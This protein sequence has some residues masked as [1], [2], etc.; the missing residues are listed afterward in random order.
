MSFSSVLRGAAGFLP[1]LIASAAF[2]HFGPLP[3]SLV[4]APVP[5]VPGLTDG[6]DPIVVDEAAA[7]ALGKALFWDVN[8][9]SDGMACASCHFHA[10]SDGRVVNQIAPQGKAPFVHD[11]VFSP[12]HGPNTRLDAAAFPLFQTDDPLNP[13]GA[14][15][16][17]SDDVVS[18]SGSFGGDFASVAP[19]GGPN[20]Q[21]ERAADSVFHVGA[22]GTRRVEPR[23]APTVIN[24]VFNFRN[25][26][27]G[28]ANNVF[29]GSSQWGDRDPEAG[30]WVATGPASVEKQRLHLENA[31]LASQALGPPLSDVEMSCAQRNFAEL[32]R[33]LACRRPL[34]DQEV[35]WE[36]GVLG[37]L[38]RSTPGQLERGL[39]TNYF[40]LVTEAFAAKYWSS[41]ARGDFGA[42][43]GGG[44]AYS[45][46]EANFAMFFG[47]AIQLYEA[48]LIS[49]DSPF[50]RSA[51]DAN[52]IPVELSV[53]EQNGFQQFR[54]A[55]CGLCH[56]GPAFT[57]E[58]DR[59]E[60]GD[61]GGGSAGV[62]LRD[63][64]DQHDA[65]RRDARLRYG[66][67][68]IL[69]T[70]FANNGVALEEWDRG[71]GGNDP[72][73]N[74]LSF[75]DQYLQM[76]AGNAPRSSI[77]ASTRCVPATS[78]FRSRST[79]RRSIRRSSARRRASSAVAE[80]PELLPRT[81]AFLPTPA[82]AAAELA[83]STNTRMRSAAAGSFKI[84]TLRNIELT[85]PYMHNGSMATLDEVLEFYTRGG[86][87]DPEAKHFG[88]VFPQV[89]LRF[90]AQARADI[91]AFLRTL[92][93]DRVRFE[94]APF[95]HPALLVPHGHVGDATAIERG[96]SARCGARRRRVPR[97]FPPWA[98]TDLQPLPE[99]ALAARSVRRALSRSVRHARQRARSAGSGGG[100]RGAGT[101]CDRAARGRGAAGV[102]AIAPSRFRRTRRDALSRLR[103]HAASAA[104]AVQTARG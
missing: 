14:V 67:P 64:H 28:A 58:R 10:G 35:H 79:W 52:G 81:G 59:D 97:G 9:G 91:I 24:S 65:Q 77:P 89:E 41:E 6:P 80:H 42:P 5:E 96:Q 16:R 69:D 72:F 8:V 61:G 36:D 43:A 4:G 30:V 98:R 20:D 63:L 101:C 50:D 3:I 19:S 60:R 88:T 21:C 7:I 103:Q 76:L 2:A 45:Q 100:V 46:Y 49:D 75:A 13:L 26:W 22:N 47:L 83:S 39:A 15:I 54:V 32:A 55:H 34:E 1:L 104:G 57:A 25:L 31:S 95:D 90:D 56:I 62:R 87:F 38:A 102:R 18:S 23:N 86:N 40:S 85:G 93:D 78:T 82:A 11:P 44:A 68:G 17:S 53:S 66:G 94:R 99:F 51:V 33:K 37:P 84:P 27:D 71:L 12:A 73:G 29:N 70:G 74:P 48:T 92:T